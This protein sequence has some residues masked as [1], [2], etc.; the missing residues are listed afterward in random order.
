MNIKDHAVTGERFELVY[1]KAMDLWRTSPQ[2]VDLSPYYDSD[3]Y[4]SHTDS[5]ISLADKLYQQAKRISLKRKLRLIRQ[6]RQW[7]ENTIGCRG[8]YRG[9]SF[10]GQ[11]N[12]LEGRRGRT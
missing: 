8:R 6:M 1:D 12:G 5:N 7:H 11:A 10:G 3:G 4:I 9:F 2:P